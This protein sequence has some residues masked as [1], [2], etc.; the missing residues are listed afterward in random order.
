MKY[1][2]SEHDSFREIHSDRDQIKTKFMAHEKRLNHKKESLFKGIANMMKNQNFNDLNKWGYL[3]EGGTQELH[4]KLEK[5]SKNKEAAF[6]YMLQDETRKVEIEREELSF[7]SNQCL[8]EIRR[9]G[10]DNGKLLID[11]FIQM[12]QTQCS[13][14][15][16]VSR[17]YQV[18]SFNSIY[19]YLCVDSYDVG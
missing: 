19:F 16:N 15:N 10:T 18:I 3:G 8:D 6:T 1:H 17:F 14:I 11:H 9:V 12:S 2:L 5:L 7:Y 4:E 13:Y